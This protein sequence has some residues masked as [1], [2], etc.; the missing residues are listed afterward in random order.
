V[1]D[2]FS[3]YPPSLTEIKSARTNNAADAAPR[4]V[5]IEM[6]RDLDSGKINPTAIVICY[7]SQDPDG[8]PVAAFRA[9]SP[10]ALLSLGLLTRVSHRLTEDVG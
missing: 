9:A 3:N 1:T 4:D 5:L 2:D 7:A 10:N 8:V 6:L